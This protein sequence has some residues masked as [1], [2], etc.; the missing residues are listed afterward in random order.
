MT[1][2]RAKKESPA[3]IAD[4]HAWEYH[5]LY[6]FVAYCHCSLRVA[7]RVRE[8]GLLTRIPGGGVRRVREVGFLT[9]IPGGGFPDGIGFRRS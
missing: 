2:P 1:H 4:P 5:L 8:V 6:F 3:R 7:G 9:R